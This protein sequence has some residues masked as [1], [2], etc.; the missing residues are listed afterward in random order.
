VAA[1]LLYAPESTPLDLRFRV[2]GTYVR[3]HPL[4]WL[5]GVILGAES[6]IKHPVLPGNGLVDL[7][8]WI[9]CVFVS[10]LLHELGHIWMGRLFG[11]EGHILLY[12]MG[13]LAIG[14]NNLSARWQ[15]ILVS[16]AGP[17]IQL[18]L[19]AIL[20]GVVWVSLVRR[21]ELFVVL[22]RD[23]CLAPTDVLEVL[24]PG[25]PAIALLLGMLLMINFWW[26]V[27]NL[28]PVW[29]LDGG[30]IT[31]E[32]CTGTSGSRGVLVSLWISLIFSAALAINALWAMNHKG[33]GFLPYLG[34]DWWTAIL[35]AYFAV[36]SY[37]AIQLETSR[38]RSYDDDL[39]WER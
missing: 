27:L 12:G 5:I 6:A 39:P 10:I 8:L 36:G 4:F 28:L 18:L 37:Q 19:W 21:G 25:K 15:R 33:K 17:L 30:M 34:G 23:A 31:R 2:L 3:V 13:G 16:F 22:L 20:V 11:S 1:V 38:S 9:F 7:A 29:P 14:S 32:V 26:P 24:L 35:F